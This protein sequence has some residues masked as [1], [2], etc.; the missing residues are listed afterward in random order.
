MKALSI[1]QPWAWL[2]VNGYKDVE[3]RDWSTRVRGRVAIHAGKK[4]DEAGI[5]WVRR[6]FPEIGLPDVYAT[7]G[8][9]GTADLVGCFDRL[10]SPWFQG[11][12]GFVLHDA[13]PCAR[14]P[15]RGQ[16]GFFEVPE[17]LLG[18]DDLTASPPA[19]APLSTPESGDSL[20]RSDP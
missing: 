4:I 15:L 6:N 13:M 18:D 16:L 19:K 1:Q 5:H 10:R 9:V 8:I 20:S 17:S 11:R 12:Y 2:I 3:N 14:I 7:G